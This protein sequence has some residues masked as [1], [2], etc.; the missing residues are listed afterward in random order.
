MDAAPPT[1]RAYAGS[2]RP[3]VPAF[4]GMTKRGMTNGEITLVE[5]P[6]DANDKGRPPLRESGPNSR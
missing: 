6:N 4:A 3:W 5:M 1:M 2:P